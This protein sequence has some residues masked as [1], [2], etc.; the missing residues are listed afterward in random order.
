MEDIFTLAR[1]Y[2]PTILILEDIDALGITGQRGESGSGAGLS[3]LLNCMDGIN[4]NNGVISI[5]TSNHPEHMDWALIARPGRFDVRIDYPYPEHDILKSIMELKLSP[6]SCQKNLNLDEL[7]SI[8][9]LGFTGSHIHDIVNQANYICL[10]NSK[11]DAIKVKITQ[12][13]LESATIR[14]LY[15]FKKFLAERPQIELQKPPSVSEVLR[16][17]KD[18]EYYQ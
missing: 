17:K 8:M 10:N 16:G 7:V 6:Y 18:Q 3:T 1:R 5:A 9:P 12:K 2:A 14:T 13:A 4:S 15:N 11:D